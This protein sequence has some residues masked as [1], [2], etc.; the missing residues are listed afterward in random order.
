MGTFTK[1]SVRTLRSTERGSDHYGLCECCGSPVSETFV[2][3]R[4]PVFERDD[5]RLYLGGAVL[6]AYGHEACLRKRFPDVLAHASLQRERNVLVLPESWTPEALARKGV[7][8]GFGHPYLDELISK[9][10][11]EKV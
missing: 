8:H 10:P 9:Y 4:R 7:T 1:Y 3:E 2:S 5:G 11:P 6:S